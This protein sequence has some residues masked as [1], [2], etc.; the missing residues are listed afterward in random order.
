MK[1]SKFYAEELAHG[2]A[3]ES[4][5]SLREHYGPNDYTAYIRDPDR[6]R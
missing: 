2:N 4:A 3:D 6:N 5:P 1:Q